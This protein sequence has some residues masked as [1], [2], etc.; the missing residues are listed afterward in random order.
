MPL[1]CERQ[2]KFKLVDHDNNLCNPL[3][4]PASLARPILGQYGKNMLA[5]CTG[6]HRFH[7][8]SLSHDFTFRLIGLRN[9]STGQLY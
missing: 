9:R 2:Q 5:T 8:P 7:R 1:L 3:T 6:L 4:P